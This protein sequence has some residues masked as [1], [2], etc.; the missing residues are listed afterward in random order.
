MTI[1]RF[2]KVNSV[3]LELELLSDA[4]FKLTQKPEYLEVQ[5][6]EG[7]A[8]G[9]PRAAQA[10]A[11][12]ATDKG[13]GDLELLRTE[14][15]GL[16][17]EN[18]AVRKD[19]IRLE[20]EN[21]RLKKEL[22]ESAKQIEEANALSRSLQARVNFMEE[23]VGRLQSKVGKTA[24]EPRAGGPSIALGAA[25]ATVPAPLPAPITAPVTAS[26][27]PDGDQ[28]ALAVN[29]AVAAW[30][31]AW[32][33]KN[34]GAYASFYAADFHALEMGRDAWIADKKKK[35]SSKK[36]FN[37]AADNVKIGIE[38]DGIATVVFEQTYSTGAYKDRGLKRLRLRNSGGNWLIISEEW[39]PL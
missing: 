35:F 17:A 33:E 23:Q 26:P 1:V 31:D 7:S 5:V 29:Q 38:P 2:P 11:A 8:A 19:V 9:S 3:R 30:L 27:K 37:I 22:A 24:G 6:S 10:S 16:R 15:D 20:E 28:A 32:R 13:A 39:S 21:Q 4:P 25:A 12:A 34:I 14:N 18:L 36:K